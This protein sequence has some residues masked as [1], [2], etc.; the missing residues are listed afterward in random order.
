MDDMKKLVERYKRELMEYSKTA[1][2]EPP[3]KLSFPE[4]TEET[5]EAAQPEAAE[6]VEAMAAEAPKKPEIIGYSNNSD[7]MSVF[8][9]MFVPD[10]GQPTAEGAEGNAPE[11][12]P[13]MPD[14]T[15]ITPPDE[16]EP[17]TEP[18]PADNG[19]STVTPSEA[20]ELGDIPESGTTPDEQLGKRDFEKKE[21]VVNNRDDIAPLRQQG[22]APQITD[23]R[24]Y[25]TLQEFT[26][27]NNR[28]G[29]ARFRTYTARGALPV[30]GA[31]ITVYKTIGGQKHIF[32]NLITD[33]S[34]QTPVI[35]LPAPPKELSIA[36][37][38]TVNPYSVY[39]ADVIAE[40]FNDVLISNMP[41][42]EGILSVQKVALVPELNTNQPEVITE[43]EPDLN[44]GV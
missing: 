26:D 1:R 30:K 6:A 14:L 34:G 20:E 2:P 39:N 15:E 16:A 37:E 23:D 17:T 27:A 12:A 40:G 18:E 9:D 19:V 25:S 28:R 10:V 7:L 33:M 41:I 5:A 8:S 35:S 13:S 21:P 3:K 29:T 36:P 38:S 44:G 22:N 42:F 43:S 32:Y 11:Y 31:K 4:M 24:I